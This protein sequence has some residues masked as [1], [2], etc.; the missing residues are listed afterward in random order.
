M[1]RLVIALSIAIAI[2]TA[3]QSHAFM[4]MDH[5]PN[6]SSHHEIL[7]DTDVEDATSYVD[8]CLS[9]EKYS[10]CSEATSHYAS[11]FIGSDL[12]LKSH[13]FKSITLR[14]GS[15][16]AQLNA[17]TASFELPPPKT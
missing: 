8:M 6:Q 13:N 7:I 14:L 5:M 16:V 17:C 3:G 11:A 10:C 9:P 15:G 4:A 12:S 2:L 1:T